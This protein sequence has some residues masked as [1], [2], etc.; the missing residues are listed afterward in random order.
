MNS[1]IAS[2]FAQ[3]A[4]PIELHQKDA[5]CCI[6]YHLMSRHDE[7]LALASVLRG[8]GMIMLSKN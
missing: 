8:L 4:V 1:N 2:G 7:K 5:R 6:R 3:A